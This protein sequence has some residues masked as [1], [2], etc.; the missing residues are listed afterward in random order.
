M[1]LKHYKFQPN[2]YVL[3]MKNGEAVEYGDTAQVLKHPREE[4][5]RI[6]LS[7]VPKLRRA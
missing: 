2:E 7:A 1:G 4:Y 5:T 6:L 3:V